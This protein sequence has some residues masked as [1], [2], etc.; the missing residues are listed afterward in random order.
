MFFKRALG[1]ILLVLLLCLLLQSCAA[2]RGVLL[3]TNLE[4]GRLYQVTPAPPPARAVGHQRPQLDA[5]AP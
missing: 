4:E 2:H 5:L 1:A 3:V